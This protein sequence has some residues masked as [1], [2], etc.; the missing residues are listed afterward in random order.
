MGGGVGVTEGVGVGVTDGV[1]VGVTEGV[2]VTL[3][4]GV[5]VMRQVIWTSSK[6]RSPPRSYQVKT[7]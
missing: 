3:G 1:G 6:A 4:V 2:G 7:S 5:G